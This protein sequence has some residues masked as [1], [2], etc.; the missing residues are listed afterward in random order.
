MRYASETTVPVE[1]SKAE[2]EQ[3]LIRYKATAFTSGWQE[4]AAFIAFQ[5]KGLYIRFTLPVPNRS[6]KRFTH[7]VVRGHLTKRTEGQAERAWEQEHRQ[8]WRALLLVV[9]AKLEAVEI[10]ISSLE[11]E[12][13][14]FIVMPGDVQLGDWL[15]ANAIPSI[16]DGRMPLLALPP[17]AEPQEIEGEVV[18]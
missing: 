15:I 17:R 12:F 14:A 11:H 5:I 2:I 1:R 6:E 9:K 8:R 18:Q 7:K 10:G 3:L 4:G 16:R 13:L